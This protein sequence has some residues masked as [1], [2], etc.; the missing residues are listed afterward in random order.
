M[1]TRKRVYQMMAVL[2]ATTVLSMIT[3]LAKSSLELNATTVAL[4]YLTVVLSISAFAGLACGIAVALAS[5]LLVNYFFLPPFGTLY[6]SSPEDWVSF[7][8]YTIV[9]LVVSHFSATVREGAVEAEA[10]KDQLEKLSRFMGRLTAVRKDELTLEIIVVELRQA[11]RLEY[12]AIYNYADK[13]GCVMPVSSGSRPSSLM[14]DVSPLAEQPNSL[15]TVFNEE[16][17]ACL[18]L[19][20]S[21]R[22]Q[23]TGMLI[24]SRISLSRNVADQ[25]TGFVSFLTKH[26]NQNIR[27]AMA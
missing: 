11:L 4:L 25:L 12:C 14:E 13:S 3:A 26:H 22:G 23:Q 5:G 8:V 20:L 6:I 1:T 24:I 27:L 7:G 18:Y 2:G 10:M 21:D 17:S 9:A 15:I 16:G 19:S